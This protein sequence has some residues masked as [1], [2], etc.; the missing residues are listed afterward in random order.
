[1]EL[2]KLTTVGQLCNILP[3]PLVYE[4]YR[5]ANKGEREAKRAGE[6]EMRISK[7]IIVDFDHIHNFIAIIF[8]I[9]TFF[10][11]YHFFFL[12]SPSIDR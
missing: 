3:L 6:D 12:S 4:T 7:L 11:F 1:M 2:T 10:L 8:N 9:S 5:Q